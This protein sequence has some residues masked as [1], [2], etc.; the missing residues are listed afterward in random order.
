MGLVDLRGPVDRVTDALLDGR[1]ATLERGFRPTNAVVDGVV[2]VIERRRDLVNAEQRIGVEDERNKELTGGEFRIV[3]RCS[4]R[5]YPGIAAVLTPDAWRVFGGLDGVITT[6]GTGS[7][8][9]GVLESSLD[10]LIERL[11]PKLYSAER[12]E[13]MNHPAEHRLVEHNRLHS[14]G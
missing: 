3:E 13:L 10:A 1:E 12:D 5:V 7:V 6:V 4:E 8:L 9:P 14:A 2:R 11:E